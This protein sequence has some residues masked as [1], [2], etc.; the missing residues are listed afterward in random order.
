MLTQQGLEII[1]KFQYIEVYWHLE[2]GSFCFITRA[3]CQTTYMHSDH[4]CY[5]VGKPCILQYHIQWCL[6][7]FCSKRA[8]HPLNLRYFVPYILTFCPSV[9]ISHLSLRQIHSLCSQHF[10]L[11]RAV[12]TCKTKMWN[13]FQPWGSTT[14]NVTQYSTVS[15]ELGFWQN[16]MSRQMYYFLWYFIWKRSQFYNYKQIINSKYPEITTILT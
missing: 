3:H 5:F 6:F 1:S 15:F 2:K 11:R 12:K 8:V 9:G 14:R 7:L 4:I 16:N 10:C 13:C